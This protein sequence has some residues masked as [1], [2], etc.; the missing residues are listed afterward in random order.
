MFQHYT[1][2]Q[3]FPYNTN[4]KVLSTKV[5]LTKLIS[6]P[7]SNLQENFSF[8]NIYQINVQNVYWLYFPTAW[9]ILKQN[10]S[11]ET[12]YGDHVQKPENGHVHFVQDAHIVY[13]DANC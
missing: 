4:T 1:W 2:F 12:Q 6:T 5:H 11:S 10:Q 7:I 8:Q 13:F 3:I 9:M